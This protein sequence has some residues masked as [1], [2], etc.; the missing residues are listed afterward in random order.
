MR[1]PKIL[2]DGDERLE[3]FHADG[4]GAAGPIVAGWREW[5]ALPE[6][7]IAK[8]RAKL[9]TGA[10]SSALHVDLIEPAGRDGA[11]WVRFHIEGEDGEIRHEMPVA[12]WRRIKNSAGAPEERAVI[13][14]PLHFAGQ[15]WM[16]DLS[17]TNRE[18]MVLPML[19]GRR[20]MARRLLVDPAR[21]WLW[22]KP[23]MWRSS[24]SHRQD[25]Q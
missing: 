15:V 14:T 10:K 3:R 11:D 4:E 13:R 22:Q 1:M 6:L 20:A 8:I 5:V 24:R 12:C 7:G 19:V 9:D 21:S 23:E 16:V 2:L 25:R 18:R 17:L